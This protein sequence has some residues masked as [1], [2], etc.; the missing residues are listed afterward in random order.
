VP[1]QCY[2]I[3]LSLSVTVITYGGS[4][5]SCFWYICS[6]GLTSVI[7]RLQKL[8][9]NFLV[10]NY[11]EAT[12]ISCFKSAIDE[13]G[14]HLRLCVCSSSWK[15]QG[16]KIIFLFSGFL[17]SVDWIYFVTSCST[18]HFWMY[19]KILACCVSFTLTTSATS[20]SLVEILRTTVIRASFYG[21]FEKNP[22]SLKN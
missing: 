15:D 10:P 7:V 22:S 12:K 9:W 20:W 16:F 13:I 6:D 2:P 8:N 18:A 4:S 21:S 14:N 3:R 17:S 5:E 1:F 11:S 19:M